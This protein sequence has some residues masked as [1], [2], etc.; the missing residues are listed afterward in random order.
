MANIAVD[1]IVVKEAFALDALCIVVVAAIVANKDIVAVGIDSKGN[2]IGGKIL[3]ALRA[4][5]VFVVKT[6]RA[7]V[8]AVMNHSHLLFVEVFFAVLAKAIVLVQAVFADM[9]AF[10]VAI[11]DF[12]SFGAKILALLTEFGSVV[13]VVAEKPLGKFAGAGNAKPIGAD[14]ENLEIV[15]MVLA[16]GDFGVEVRVHPITISAEAVAAIEVNV[17]FVT[18]VFFGLPKIG[19]AFKLGQF[20]L[21]KV[22]I[23]F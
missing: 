14:L 3:V 5:Q 12:P 16:N 18:A 20:A 4:K 2:V 10:A 11:D 8:G 15:G 13:T 22:A 19:N 7:N 9:N 17:V 23:K 6:M 1:R 21:N